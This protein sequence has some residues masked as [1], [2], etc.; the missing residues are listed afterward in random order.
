MKNW[1][2]FG[3]ILLCGS[4]MA[5]VPASKKDLV[6]KVLSLQQAVIEQ[7]AQAVAERPALQMMQQAS[8]A[9]QT[10]VAPEKREQIGKDIEADIKKYAEQV[11]P[12]IR[13]H[14][15]KIAPATVGALLEKNFN[16]KELTELIGIIESPVNR[17]FAQMGGEL[18]KALVEQLVKDVQA[19]IDPKLK[20]L[21]QAIVKHLALPAEE[22]PKPAASKAAPSGKAKK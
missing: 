17:K 12:S 13:Q 18:Q 22:S 3:L 21:E 1:V 15:V 19:D 6:N 9:L 7:T 14:A 11:V 8:M 4:A 5:Q 2:P 10:R 20:A 16:E